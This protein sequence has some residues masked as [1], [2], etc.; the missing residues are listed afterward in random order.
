M[1]RFESI[2][3][4]QFYLTPVLQFT[5]NKVAKQVPNKVVSVIYIYIRLGQKLEFPVAVQNL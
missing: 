1:L 3:C 5:I 2:L 4:F